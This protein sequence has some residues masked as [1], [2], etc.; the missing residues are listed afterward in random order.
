MCAYASLFWETLE[1]ETGDAKATILQGN[2]HSIKQNNDGGYQ[3]SQDAGFCHC[4]AYYNPDKTFVTLDI[5]S[6]PVENSVKIYWLPYKKG[7]VTSALRSDYENDQTCQYFMTPRLEGCRFVLTPDKVLH[8]ASDASGAA[9]GPL[10]SEKRTAATTAV[11]GAQSSRRLSISSN[12][13]N[14]DWDTYGYDFQAWTFG[15]RR[16]GSWQYKSLIRTDKDKP[17]QWTTFINP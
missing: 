10:G 2:G 17:G 7:S 14:A 1:A 6:D 9:A 15:F 3:S 12:T 13:M 8:V 5:I 4:G 16:E 11:I